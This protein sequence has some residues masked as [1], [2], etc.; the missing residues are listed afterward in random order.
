[1]KHIF[2]N[3]V[4]LSCLISFDMYAQETS[5]N[6]NSINPLEELLE[7]YSMEENVQNILISNKLLMSMSKAKDTR[8]VVKNIDSLKIFSIT[9]DGSKKIFD[10]FKSKLLKI[11]KDKYFIKNYYS[12]VEIYTIKKQLKIIN[13]KDKKILFVIDINKTNISVLTIKGN[14]TEEVVSSVINGDISFS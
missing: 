9:K 2:I 8:E 12:L 4:L 10:D 1:M 13:S 5:K 6:N 11:S 3:I 14:I 7:N